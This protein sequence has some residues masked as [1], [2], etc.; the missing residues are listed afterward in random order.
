MNLRYLHQLFVGIYSIVIHI[1][2]SCLI[3]INEYLKTLLAIVGSAYCQLN[4]KMVIQDNVIFIFTF[5]K[6]LS[7][8]RN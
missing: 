7:C 6:I 3:W 4:L 5:V 8:K 2:Y 1:L